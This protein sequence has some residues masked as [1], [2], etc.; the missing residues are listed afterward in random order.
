MGRKPNDE[1]RTHGPRIYYFLLPESKPTELFFSLQQMD[2]SCLFL[3]TRI[4]EGTLQVTYLDKGYL[5]RHHH[6]TVDL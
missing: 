3:Y 2:I 1:I 4:T 5:D 6:I